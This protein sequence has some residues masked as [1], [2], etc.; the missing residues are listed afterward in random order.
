MGPDARGRTACGDF[1]TAVSDPGRRRGSLD[2]VRRGTGRGLLSTRLP[3]GPG[4]GR[5]VLP[6][7]PFVAAASVALALA[8]G[9]VA[10]GGLGWASLPPAVAGAVAAV[11]ARPRPVVGALTAAVALL[12][13][14]VLA[15]LTSAADVAPPWFLDIVPP[16]LVV[17]WAVA[18]A[19]P[20]AVAAA[21][22]GGLLL[23]GLAYTVLVMPLPLPTG[24]ILL[25]AWAA[26]V[27]LAGMIGARRRDRH[28]RTERLIAE[29]G[30]RRVRAEH[31]RI[32]RELHDAVAHHLSE[33]AVRAVSAPRRIA[34]VTDDA[35]AEFGALG[36]LARSALGEMRQLLGVLRGDAAPERVPQ[37]GLADLPGL[38]ESVRRAGVEVEL[39]LVEP[40]GLPV[41]TGLSAYRI[42]QEAL[43]NVIRHA[44]GA[45]T[46]VRVA[47]D[48]PA[49]RV[50]VVNGPPAETVPPAPGAGLGLTG[51]RERARI[52]GGRLEAGPVD[53]GGFAVRAELP[54]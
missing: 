40:P 12:A 50:E 27:G 4:T 7:W 21:V 14:A 17:A 35:A 24:F 54:R 3:D 34:G 19:L 22:L 10:A 43:S 6:W 31:D 38:A 51:M 37:P 15:R 32:A 16:H 48:G 47:P 41:G 46:T 8:V 52:L 1:S 49:L 18:V 26:V 2:A 39:E 28:L 5:P 13:A 44:A 53:G 25:V 33:L 42:V 30:E 29:A 20:G 11:L 36:G 23:S 45:R 9:V